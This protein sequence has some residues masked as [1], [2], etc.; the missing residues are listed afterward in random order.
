AVVVRVQN[1]LENNVNPQAGNFKAILAQVGNNLPQ[2]TDPTKATGFDQVEL[3]VYG[4]CSDLTSGS[5]PKMKSVY[6]V[7]PTGT[8]ASNQQAL[9]N[10]GVRMLD[11]YVAGLASQSSAS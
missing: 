11:Q 7:N 2:S 3:M 4:A 5:T 9:I 1:G 8:V 10:A 6:S